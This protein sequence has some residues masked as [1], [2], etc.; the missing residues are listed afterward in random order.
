M[1]IT[2][3]NP[4]IISEKKPDEYLSKLSDIIFSICKTDPHFKKYKKHNDII[5][6]E[7]KTIQSKIIKQDEMLEQSKTMIDDINAKI[8]MI[9]SENFQTR[10]QILEDLGSEI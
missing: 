9:S 1:Q 7:S 8:E 6:S 5:E 4:S 10:A 2:K 3:S